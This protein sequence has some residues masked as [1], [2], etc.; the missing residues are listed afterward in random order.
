MTRILPTETEQEVKILLIGDMGVGKSSLARQF[1]EEEPREGLAATIGVDFKVRYVKFGE[2]RKLK[3]AVWDTAGAERFRTL[4][5]NYYRGV[6]AYIM[7][8]D[9]TD[10]KSFRNL[11]YW[12][13]EVNRNSTIKDAVKLIIANKIDQLSDVET[14]EGREFAADHVSLFLETSARTGEGVKLAF[15]ELVL[16]V[17]EQPHLLVDPAVSFAIHRTEPAKFTLS[18]C[19]C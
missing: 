17:V 14:A 11:E 13:D 7:V 2:K 9:V 15:D 10:R 16:K 8:Y 3:V 4:T 1:A 6:H 18:N 12:I 5:A 19:L